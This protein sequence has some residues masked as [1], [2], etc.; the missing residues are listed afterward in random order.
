MAALTRRGASALAWR[1]GHPAGHGHR[2]DPPDAPVPGQAHRLRATTR[3]RGRNGSRAAVGQA[4]LAAAAPLGYRTRVPSFPDP[5]LRD[6]GHAYYGAKYP[7]LL[8]VKARYDP[9]NRFRSRQS[10]P[11][12]TVHARL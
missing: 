3:G 7:R 8:A 11:P 2:V 4:I 5:D 12:P 1:L 6:W 10:L 9:G